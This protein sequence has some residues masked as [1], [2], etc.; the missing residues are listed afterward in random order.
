MAIGRITGPMLFSNLE[1]Q[2]VDL[3]IDA[4][5]IYA[6]VGSRMVGINNASPS[7]ALDS[8][9]NARISGLII[10]G[11]TITSNTGK[12]NLG[13]TTNVVMS[14]GT[15]YDVLYT[16]GNGNL[17]FGNLNYLSGLDGFTG[18]NI[19]LGANTSGAFVSNAVTLTSS[20]S[21]T[22]SIAELNYVLGKLVPPAPPNFPNATTITI[23]SAT[24]SG[25]MCN[26]TQTDNTATQ[27]KNVVGGTAM[28]VVRTATFNTSAVA[29]VGPGNMGTITAYVNG[30]PRGNVTLT[31]SNANTNNGNLWVYGVRDYHD[32]ISTVTAGFWTVFS[33]NA[34]ATGGIAQGWNEVYIYDSATSTQTNTTSWYYDASTPGTPTFS[35][36]S[37]SLTSNSVTY[38]STIPHFNSS[39]TFKIKGNIS[40]LSGDLYY[41]GANFITGAAAGAFAT[42]ASVTYAAAGV[43]TPLARNLYVSSG[44]A[45]FESSVNITTG[46]GSSSVGPTLSGFSPY[47]TGSSGAINPG[48]TILYKTGTANTVEETAIPVSVSLGGGYSTNA[49]RIVNPDAGTAV[50]NPVYTGSEAAFNSQTGPF[51]TTD[52][53]VSANRLKFDQTNYSTGYLPVGPNLSTQGASQYF[54]FKFQRTTVSKFD[55]AITATGIAGMW[56]ALP[57]VS[58]TS[59]ASPTNGWWNMNVAYAGSGA[60]GTGAGSNGSA[61]CSLGGLV[62]LNTALAGAYTATFGTLSSS[63]STSNEIYVRIK[64]TSG[65][66]ISAL[67]ITTASH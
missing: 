16:D 11:N 8:P 20:S 18:N 40:N 46:F 41:S 54:T 64:L 63:S 22:N 36:T 49:W 23:T 5:L 2:G 27:G 35:N 29:N 14:G 55:I 17:S 67:S 57:G 33:A 7:Y 51:Y 24:I 32:V 52:A 56:V 61:G 58:E 15:P 53:T 47:A 62:P 66:S 34:A 4:N 44:S 31:G 45:Y 30:T 28:N 38:S 65:Q 19:T 3:A 13:S 1:R 25:L 42:P 21:V 6:S 37:I 60:P 48:V 9:G 12:I 26:F 43:T 10:T 50:D 39:S 59:Y